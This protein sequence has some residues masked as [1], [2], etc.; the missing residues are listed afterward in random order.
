[1]C[2][3]CEQSISVED[4]TAYGYET[5]P[6]E[7]RME[8]ALHILSCLHKPTPVSGRHTAL[9]SRALFNGTGAGF[10]GEGVEGN[11]P[12]CSHVAAQ[13]V[14]HLAPRVGAEQ[15]QGG[16]KG[17]DQANWSGAGGMRSTKRRQDRTDIRAQC[18]SHV[19]FFSKAPSL[20]R[21]VCSMREC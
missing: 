5:R 19:L 17:G 4:S 12:I 6:L 20:S 18:L 1:M 21:T 11:V 16:G 9:F 2:S 14:V 15:R 10:V 3:S 13:E 7:G 8:V